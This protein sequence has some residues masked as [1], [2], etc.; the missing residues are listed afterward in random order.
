MNASIF[1][2]FG[3][4]WPMWAVMLTCPDF[5][6]KPDKVSLVIN[7]WVTAVPFC[8]KKKKWIQRWRHL[9]RVNVIW[10]FESKLCIQLSSSIST[11]DI[12][13]LL[14]HLM[15]DGDWFTFL[16]LVFL[17]WIWCMYNY[18]RFVLHLWNFLTESMLLKWKH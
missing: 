5:S 16:S 11:F 14:K 9:S 6:G 13:K 17:R 1:L 10:D 12:F 2:I 15:V 7:E 8:K 3:H 18:T 4:V